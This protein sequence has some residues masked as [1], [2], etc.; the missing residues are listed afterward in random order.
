MHWEAEAVTPESAEE[1]P[2]PH[3]HDD[4]AADQLKEKRTVAL[5]ALLVDA[6][7]AVGEPEGDDGDD[8]VR[9]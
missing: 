4:G 9:H 7:D 1:Q 8:E 5:G 2:C 3:E 6:E